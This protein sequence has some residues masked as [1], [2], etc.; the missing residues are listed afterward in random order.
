MAKCRDKGGERVKDEQQEIDS[1]RKTI[2]GLVREIVLGREREEQNLAEFSA[3]NNEIITTQRLLAKSNAELKAAKEEADRANRAKGDFLSM[4]SHEIRT[5]M[6]GIT[7]MAELLEG[8]FLSD[9][10][11]DYVGVIR[12]SADYL[13]RM[14]NDL[15]DLAKFEAGGLA[16]DVEELNIRSVLDHVCRL[17]GPASKQRGNELGCRIGDRVAEN[18]MGDRAKITRMLINLINNAV[19]F[20]YNGQIA[21]TISVVSE[22]EETQRLRFEVSDTGVGISSED[23]QRLF[24]PYIQAQRREGVSAEG[25]GLGLAITKAMA[26]QMDGQIGVDSELGLGSTFWFELP[27]RK[28][29]GVRE[30]NR[31]AQQDAGSPSV[32]PAIL[33]AEDQDLGAKL[34]AAQL[35]KLGAGEVRRVKS[36]LEAVE[37]W[38]REDYGLIL[39]D[40]QL[41]ELDGPEAAQQIRELEAASGRQRTPIV[42]LSGDVTEEGRERC[43]RAGMDDWA[44][45]PVKLS[46]LREIVERWAAPGITPVLNMQTAGG[47]LELDGDEEPA[48][49]RSLLDMFKAD[50]PSR[51]EQL[52]AAFAAG[53]LAETGRI[54]HSLKSGSLGLGADYFASLC[55]DVE[56]EARSGDGPAAGAKLPLLEGAYLEA[57]AALEQ[58]A[59]LNT[60]KR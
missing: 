8:S 53:D 23:M 55:A 21:V 26:E 48:I 22:S 4:V 35:K 59:V 44:A 56:R 37:A 3:M 39:L 34:L 18:L 57:C 58:L 17:L 11:R 13:L 6:N 25:T 14:I 51:L 43:L 42:A 12:E 29:A 1:L 20:T 47:I 2:E 38:M 28:A 50:T 32:L 41:E 27:L 52:E 5:P 49:L 24:L 7:G 31:A 36:G 19:K 15:L 9:E 45:K 46:R 33:L 16:L 40:S 10:Q 30:D 54:A 60:V